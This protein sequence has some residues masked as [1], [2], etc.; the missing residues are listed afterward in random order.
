MEFSPEELALLPTLYETDLYANTYDSLTY[1]GANAKGVLMLYHN[2]ASTHD[3]EAYLQKILSS[4]N[5]SIDD[6]VLL[7][8]SDYP[9]LSWPVLQ[10]LFSPKYVFSFACGTCLPI[11]IQPTQ[12]AYL[13][14]TLFSAFSAISNFKVADI[15]RRA[16][17]NILL[18]EF[19]N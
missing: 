15:E 5:L 14:N 7:N 19:K 3:D 2:T 6:A 10:Q 8:T 16:L 13:S 18:R 12:S 1:A 9:H 4:V 17:H 11:A